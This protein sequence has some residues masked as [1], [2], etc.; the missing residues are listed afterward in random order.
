MTCLSAF[1]PPSR[2]RVRGLRFEGL[3]FRVYGLRNFAQ[4]S[5]VTAAAVSHFTRLQG[6]ALRRKAELTSP[7]VLAS[8]SAY[9]PYSLC[10]FNDSERGLWF[11][12]NMVPEIALMVP[13]RHQMPDRPKNPCEHSGFVD[14]HTATHSKIAP[15]LQA[16]L[17]SCSSCSIANCQL[18]YGLCCGKLEVEA[19]YW[20]HQDCCLLGSAS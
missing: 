1:M 6:D 20:Q 7:P 18:P 3:R 8:G 16:C 2:F 12:V 11:F 19:A 10:A 5:R 15:G 4:M 14:K 13:K 17:E 9:A